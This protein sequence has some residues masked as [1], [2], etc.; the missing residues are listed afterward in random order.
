LFVASFT[1]IL[2]SAFTLDRLRS[3]VTGP[4]DLAGLRVGVKEAATSGRYLD[5]LGVGYVTMPSIPEL[6]AALDRGQLDAVVADDPVLRHAIKTG[7]E[8][9]LYSQLMVLPYQF[10]RQS[11]GL[12]LTEDPVFLEDINRALL[13]I[14]ASDEW[15]EHVGRYL[16][17]LR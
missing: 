12:V 16:G 3:D 15:A 6:L 9:R 14:R 11:Y 2:A 10:A 8:K 7:G 4:T 13:A 1:A 5:R 17:I